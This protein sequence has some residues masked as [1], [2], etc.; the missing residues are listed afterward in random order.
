MNSLPACVE[1]PKGLFS[2]AIPLS[3]TRVTCRTID[4]SR[5]FHKR[6]SDFA[7]LESLNVFAAAKGLMIVLHSGLSRS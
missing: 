3:T 2:C 7:G 6:S 4:G 1:E 5:R